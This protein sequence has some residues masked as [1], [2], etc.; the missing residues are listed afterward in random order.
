M[1]LVQMTHDS[2]LATSIHRRQVTRPVTPVVRSLMTPLVFMRAYTHT[3]KPTYQKPYAHIMANSKNISLFKRTVHYTL[4]SRENFKPYYTHK[5]K[6][7]HSSNSCS[8]DSNSSTLMSSVSI[9]SVLWSCLSALKHIVS[10][11]CL[12]IPNPSLFSVI[13]LKYYRA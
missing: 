4:K 13:K 6:C 3:N 7:S 2:Y 9:Y 8:L 1:L 12:L 5:G 10:Q 11:Q